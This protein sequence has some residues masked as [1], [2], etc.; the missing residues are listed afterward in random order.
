ML[1]LLGALIVAGGSLWLADLGCGGGDVNVCGNGRVEP[2]EECDCGTDPENLPGNC[3]QI[4]GGVNAGC[5]SQCTLREISTNEVKVYW[6]INGESHLGAGS[7]DTCNDVDA[8]YAR[9]RLEGVGGYFADRPQQSCGQFVA[10]FTDD[11]VNAPLTAGDYTVYVELQTGE[12]TPLAPAV[13]ESFT[14]MPGPQNEVTVDF[15]LESFYAY[16]QMTGDLLF[17]LHWGA[18]NNRC[19]D[20]VPAV[21]EQTLSLTQGGSPVAGFPTQGEC[22]DSTHA[23]E[24][25]PPGD[26]DIR[27]EG[28]DASNERQ[29]CLQDTL[30]VGAGVQPSYALVVPTEDASACVD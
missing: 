19:V 6:T 29:Y 17:R 27:V 10:V 7:F 22:S 13:S 12:G 26:Y 23:V 1:S 11:P 30:K 18:M 24:D 25:L 9:V 16:D 2:G 21:A 20:A 5:S 28:F 14:L 3:N 8:S 15:P 4:N